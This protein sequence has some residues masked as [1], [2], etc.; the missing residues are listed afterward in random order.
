MRIGS[1]HLVMLALMGLCAVGGCTKKIGPDGEPLPPLKLVTIG[2][3][4]VTGVY[5]PAAGAMAKVVSEGRPVHGVKAT[6]ESTGGSEYNLNAMA[7][8]DLDL[9]IAQSDVGYQAYNGQRN[10]TGRAMKNLRSLFSLHEEPFHIVVRADAEI[11]SFDDLQGK[12]I[13]VGNPGSGQR[14]TADE[15]FAVAPFGVGDLVAGTLKASEAPDYLRDGRI[16]GY[17]YNVG[18]GAANI[19]DVGHSVD[20]DLV[21]IPDD[22]VAKLKEGRPYYVASTI[23][24]ETYPGV[25]HDTDTFAVKATLLT[26]DALADD[27]VYAIVKGVFEHLDRVKGAHPALSLLTHEKMSDGLTAPL[28]PGAEKYY[29]ER[30]WIE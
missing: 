11:A 6:I 22:L 23:P 20:I 19:V 8:G 7:R 24:A 3:G 15:L 9:G 28:H 12:R 2:A 4:S 18:V 17:F 14:L 25:D 27:I 30:G 1:G 26:T 13:N 10:F 21:S 5:F 16:D 29:R